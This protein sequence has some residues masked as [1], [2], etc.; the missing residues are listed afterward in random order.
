MAVFVV[1]CLFA[2]A[3][4]LCRRNHLHVGALDQIKS[5]HFTCTNWSIVS[6]RRLGRIVLNERI[7]D[8]CSL[9]KC[10]FGFVVCYTIRY[11]VLFL[12]PQNLQVNKD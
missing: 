7:F 12:L 8:V 4:P 10:F 1:G 5:S 3:S 2:S 11:L 6:S 9:G